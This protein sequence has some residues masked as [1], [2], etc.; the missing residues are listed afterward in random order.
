MLRRI[1]YHAGP[2]IASAAILAAMILPW[3]LVR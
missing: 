1:A 3:G 2:W